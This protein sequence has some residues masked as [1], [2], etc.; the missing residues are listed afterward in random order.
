MTIIIESIVISFPLGTNNNKNNSKR[1]KGTVP[2]GGRITLLTA[3]V[4]VAGDNFVPRIQVQ[5]FQ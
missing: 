1:R 3:L 4:A 5:G 2:Y